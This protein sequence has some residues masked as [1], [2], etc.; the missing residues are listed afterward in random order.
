MEQPLVSICIPTYNGAKYILEALVSAVNQTYTKLEIIISDDN[1]KDSTLKIVESFKS[2]T[3]I[4]IRVYK[5]TPK[6]IGENWNNCIRYAQGQ[7]IKFLFQ[8]DILEKDCIQTMVNLIESDG[9]IGLVSCKRAF[10]IQDQ[11]SSNAQ[12]IKDFGDLQEKLNLDWSKGYALIDNSLFKHKEF[13]KSPLNKIGEPTTYL[14]KKDIVNNI[15]YFDE[16]LVQILD[17]VFCYRVLK[18][19]KIAILKEPLV[20]FRLH[21]EQATKENLNHETGDSVAYKKILYKE[22]LPLLDDYMRLHF[23]KRY[24]W[25]YKLKYFIISKFRYD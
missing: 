12:W 22:F 10:I 21:N 15:G 8:D 4:P 17:Y 1:S 14:F 16:N 11:S 2:K 7:Y 9:Q 25:F 5:H 23:L 6:R 18:H 24:N 19:Y 13:L 3:N 20:K